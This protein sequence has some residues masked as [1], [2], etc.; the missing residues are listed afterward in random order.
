MITVSELLVPAQ[1]ARL[2]EAPEWLTQSPVWPAVLD[3]TGGQGLYL[4]QA[5]GLEIL[6]EG[7]NLVISTGTASGKSLIF[8]AATLHRLMEDPEARA[9]AIYPIK[10]LARDQ[11]SKWR[12]MAQTI[13]M[14]PMTIN[15]IDG[16]I[17][18]NPAG[19]AERRELLKKSR[20][21]IMTPDIIQSWLLCYSK[22]P[23]GSARSAKH[24]DVMDSQAIIRDFIRNASILIIDEAHTHDGTMGTNCMY[25]FQRL[26]HKRMLL[27]PQASPM[28]IIAASATIRNPTE[29]LE[30]LT[31][32]PFLEVAEH[33][34]GAPRAE[35]LV[36]HIAGRDVYDNGWEDLADVIQEIIGEN[37]LNRYIAFMDDRQ[38]VERTAALIETAQGITEHEIVM[39][40]KNSMSYR[41]GLMHRDLIEEAL[42][43]GKYRG[44]VSTSAMEMSIDM[45][46]LNVGLNLGIPQT[47]QRMRQRAGRVG[48]K[49]QGR[50]IMVAPDYALQLHGNTL[51]QYW[52]RP[53]EA[54]RLYPDNPYIRNTHHLC[55]MEEKEQNQASNRLETDLMLPAIQSLASSE[56]D[57][58]F[59][60]GD[61]RK[62][63]VNSLRDGTEPK[64]RII[65]TLREGQESTLTNETT[66]R[67]A[68]KEA[69][70]LSSYHH[71]KQS[72][73]IERWEEPGE[74]N[75]GAE[76]RIIARQAP[77]QNTRP[78]RETGADLTLAQEE[79]PGLGLL[80]YLGHEHA[81][82]WERITGCT[83]WSGDAWYS[84]EQVNYADVG[85]QDVETR[86]KTTATVLIIREEWFK[87]E[88]AREKVAT[89]LR[90]IMCAQ[91]GIH[92]T[93][94]RASYRNIRSSQGGELTEID[95]AVAIWD[96]TGGGL[97]IS[98]A[99][100][101]NLPAYAERLLE[102]AQ[103]PG[104]QSESTKPLGETHA[105][106]LHSWTQRYHQELATKG[107]TLPPQPRISFYKGVTFRSQLE[108][109]WAQRFD[110]MN[111]PWAYEPGGFGNWAPDF[112]L[113]LPG[114]T[115]YAEVKPVDFFPEN[116]A[117][118]IDW[119]SWDGTAMILGNRT[120]DCWTR[121]DRAWMET[122][123]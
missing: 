99:L 57:P 77:H 69:Y 25:L 1:A 67:E 83:I 26:Q 100:M 71:G 23:W 11:M 10:A 22:P 50:F 28:R 101:D 30:T 74:N 96:K 8:Q 62:P 79:L 119:S 46:E 88:T 59:T 31:G 61:P 116:I 85:I 14:D 113:K 91:E 43:S 89:A 39:K 35:L 48:R 68:L 118:K 120:Q 123:I 56:Y 15:R 9:I 111:I 110:A 58:S 3:E 64:A 65:Q 2:E 52:N 97:G 6:G 95:Q 32:Q 37:D 112:R 29:H 24:Q 90:D 54:P 117:E 80:E 5:R 70:P 106:L 104:E 60:T 19:Y 109:T 27:N 84:G 18:P 17:H 115:A 42:R 93:D 105:L 86:T 12:H 7:H 103:T 49:E 21:V 38:L 107:G 82:T 33:E 94:I 51:D 72:Y 75:P 81:Q 73:L 55:L 98:Q 40:A 41:A 108:A 76:T 16:D 20:L 87:D 36:Q 4:H 34:N 66:R 13:G 45:P 102:I 78:T 122:S 114:E 121:R 44:L 47:N 92:D 53:V 63:H